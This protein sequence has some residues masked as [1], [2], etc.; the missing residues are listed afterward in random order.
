MRSKQQMTATEKVAR[1]P[2]V[3]LDADTTDVAVTPPAVVMLDPKFI[4]NVA[5]MVRNCPAF[6]TDWLILPGDRLDIPTGR[7]GDRLPRQER[8][9]E[10]RT[11]NIVQS[12]FP[13]VL[14]RN[15]D[16]VPIGV[17]LVP[18]A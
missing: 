3:V 12:D 14:F 6:G 10:Y 17:E 9:R 11:V 15:Q 16:A 5:S 7:K 1:S 2:Y 8:M 4:V 18:G 13:T